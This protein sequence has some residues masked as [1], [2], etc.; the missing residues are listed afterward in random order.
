[1]FFPNPVFSCQSEDLKRNDSVL[2][3]ME[4][5]RWLSAESWHNYAYQ[6]SNTHIRIKKGAFQRGVVVSIEEYDMSTFISRLKFA[7]KLTNP[8]KFSYPFNR[9]LSCLWARIWVN[10]HFNLWDE[11]LDYT[12]GLIEQDASAFLFLYIL[13]QIFRSLSWKAKTPLVL[14]AFL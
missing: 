3:N 5:Y 12:A 1:M 7:C 10:Q 8:L 14:Q 9:F 13:L 2:K 11:E 6:K 4:V